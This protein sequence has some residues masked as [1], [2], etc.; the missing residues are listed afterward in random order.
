LR[1]LF[2]LVLPGEEVLLPDVG[3]TFT[4]P[5]LGGSLLEG[6]P[7]A[8]RV[9]RNGVLMLEQAAKVEEMGVRGRSLGERDRLPFFDEFAGSHG[10]AIAG[11]SDRKNSLVDP[12]PKTLPSV[13]LSGSREDKG[14]S[15]TANQVAIVGSLA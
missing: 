14:P 8:G 2:L 6:E 1:S 15:I 9:R 10:S 12:P 7:F 3:K 4:A 11:N 5:G 13:P